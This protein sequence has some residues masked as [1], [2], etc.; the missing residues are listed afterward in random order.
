MRTTHI[1]G[2][3]VFGVSLA[4]VAPGCGDDGSN[5]TG[6]E[7]GAGGGT[8]ASSGN[9]SSSSTGGQVED[10]NIDCASAD[11]LS[12]ESLDMLE[13]TLED[14]AEDRDYYTFTGKKGDAILIETDAKPTGDEFNT[15]YA[16]LVITVLGPDGKTKIAQNDDPYPLPPFSNDSEIVMVLPED[17]TYCVE[18]GECAALFGAQNCRAPGTNDPENN[19]YK[20]R[21]G[22]LNT[23]GMGLGPEK[24]PND[25]AAGATPISLVKPEMSTTYLSFYD[26]GSFSSATDVDMWSFKPPADVK[27]DAGT[28]A[29]CHF[30]FFL[31]GDEGNGSTATQD[32]IGYVATL[33]DPATRIA[34]IDTTALDTTIRPEPPGISVPCTLDTE[35]LFVMTRPQGTVAGAND[36]YFFQHYY[37]GSNPLEKGMNDDVAMPEALEQVKQMDGSFSYFVDGDLDTATDVDY[38]GV[39][40]PVGMETIGFVCE[41]QRGGSGVRGLE[42]TVLD[43]NGKPIAGGMGTNTESETK[44]IRFGGMTIPQGSTKLTFKVEAASLDPN[45]TGTYYRCGFHLEPAAP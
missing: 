34:E 23:M 35:Y 19:D 38:Y 2:L 18:V 20:I 26:W 11:E 1:F 39:T 43:A 30:D 36:F 25:M 41:G 8:P 6:G 42:V 21:A 10:T 44:Q 29:T 45:V 22:M 40:V 9:G 5:A 12:F 7:G 13:A 28:Q 31:P 4:A 3:L 33:A 17:G 15:T 27:V 32:V 24:E 16:D 14:V 37:S